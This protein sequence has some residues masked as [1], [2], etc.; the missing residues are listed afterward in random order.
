MKLIRQN[1]KK[2]IK[3]KY[4]DFMSKTHLNGIRFDQH[5]YTLPKTSRKALSSGILEVV[6]HFEPNGCQVVYYLWSLTIFY[7]YS[8][9]KVP[10]Q[11]TD[12]GGEGI[13]SFDNFE[14]IM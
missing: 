13:L 7:A 6:K 10:E 4:A 9:K 2:V 14:F 5:N 12:A 3:K 8:R 1:K 11:Q